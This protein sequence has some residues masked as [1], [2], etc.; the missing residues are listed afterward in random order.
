MKV[1]SFGASTILGPAPTQQHLPQQLNPPQQQQAQGISP[2][3]N[4]GSCPEIAVCETR[5]ERVRK[6][7]SSPLTARRKSSN[8][9]EI[10]RI[11]GVALEI[12]MAKTQAVPFV[13]SRL[14]FFIESRGMAQEGI[15]R[16]SGN[17]KL[18]DKLKASFDSQGDAPLEQEADIAAAAGLL[19]T[20]FRELPEPLIPSK[21][22]NHFLEATQTTQSDHELRLGRFRA[23]V[24]ELPEENF[25]VLRY[26]CRFL[27][28][29]SQHEETTR[30]NPSALGIVFG[31]NLFRFADDLQGLQDQATTNQAVTIFIANY[32]E[33]FEQPL[34]VIIPSD[35]GIP[36][37][38]IND[39]LLTQK[40]RSC[41]EER[42]PSPAQFPMVRL[43]RCSSSEDMIGATASSQNTSPASM[44]QDLVTEDKMDTDGHDST[45]SPVKC[46]RA[47]ADSQDAHTHTMPAINKHTADREI[48]RD[49]ERTCWQPCGRK[50]T[51]SDQE[52]QRPVINVRKNSKEGSENSRATREPS[53]SQSSTTFSVST[54]SMEF[55]DKGS[56]ESMASGVT[57]SPPAT[58]PP[59]TAIQVPPLELSH[60]EE[61]QLSEHRF[62]WPIVP[63]LAAPTSFHKA[64][65]VEAPLSPSAYR[66]YLSHRN[67]LVDEMRLPPS[68]PVGE[69]DFLGTTTHSKTR[70]DQRQ[71]T[72]KMRALK[73]KVL[74]FEAS[75]E[76]TTGHRPS[77]AEKMGDTQCREFLHEL[78]NIRKEI[79]ALQNEEELLPE[80][81]YLS[82]QRYCPDDDW[83]KSSENLE[84][85]FNDT[86]SI[87][88]EKRRSARRPERVEDMTREQVVEEKLCIQKA[89]L[90][91]ESVH[92]RPTSRADRNLMRPLYD[93]Y[94]NV[95]RIIGGSPFQA[96][97]GQSKEDALQPIPE[98][99]QME[100]NSRQNEYGTAKEIAPELQ[101]G[102]TPAPQVAEANS[103]VIE[104]RPDS[105][106]QSCNLHEL[107]LREL[108][109]EQCKARLE[110]RRLRGIL[111]QFEKEFY[112]AS[113]RKVQ[114]EDRAPMESTYVQYKHIKAK[115]RLM[116]ALVFKH[117][118][119]PKC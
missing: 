1:R 107:P 117:E 72:K 7:L 53:T 98:H 26:L 91:F 100:F 66:G 9:N 30:M 13:L 87:L 99:V 71:L 114:R 14:C 101:N 40:R 27:H 51:F 36:A 23:L 110:K 102:S 34:T 8:P 96:G 17:A 88:A 90:R 6:L 16:I 28:K 39:A 58:P 68:P 55:I 113:G 33:I 77:H 69:N 112:L 20:F 3:S 10:H 62:S 19:K 61:P 29:V 76:A 104:N 93:R 63:A 75:F 47:S 11:F 59:E 81:A 37:L 32:Y 89:L 18:I 54:E 64:N 44:L 86:L 92:G 4:G 31:P 105:E 41:S 60:E 73:K 21:M 5:L 106:N 83:E 56:I 57:P 45:S 25:M 82:W 116:E 43:R 22:Y 94:R 78:T 46:P 67:D 2:S 79:K 35:D 111:R 119:Q 50:R 103:P 95:K 15:F 49:F 115:L 42:P 12:L 97:L 118:N 80:P 108:L 38:M 109:Q 52:K 85:A 84:R 24:E 65:S 48:C 70:Q 74:T